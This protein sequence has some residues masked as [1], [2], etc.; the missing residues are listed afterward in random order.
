MNAKISN[1]EREHQ[2]L[3][4]WKRNDKLRTERYRHDMEE[5]LKEL[6]AGIQ[7]N[8]RTQQKDRLDVYLIEGAEGGGDRGVV[9]VGYPNFWKVR[10][11]LNRS[12]F[13]A[14]EGRLILQHF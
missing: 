5:S 11:W 4:E 6:T 8:D 12:L 14:G 9:G 7:S 10:S 3:M 2:E 13:F 1:L